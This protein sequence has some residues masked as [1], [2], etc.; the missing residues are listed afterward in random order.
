MVLKMQIKWFKDKEHKMSQNRGY[1]LTMFEYEP[2][3]GVQN[4]RRKN[5]GFIQGLWRTDIQCL[6]NFFEQR[7]SQFSQTLDSQIFSILKKKI[8]KI[9]FFAEIR[10]EKLPNFAGKN[11]LSV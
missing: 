10:R 4:K 3:L 6:P 2:F 9:I 8:L 7:I 11:L 5:Q 1:F